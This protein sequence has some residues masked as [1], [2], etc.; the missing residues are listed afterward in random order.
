MLR[1]RVFMTL[2]ELMMSLFW[3]GWNHLI[4]QVGII[5]RSVGT[6]DVDALWVKFRDTVQACLQL[7][8]PLRT[9]KTNVSNPWITREI[10]HLKRKV[11]R[12]KKAKKKRHHSTNIHNQILSVSKE[13]K[14]K[15]REEK[16]NFYNV[17]LSEMVKESPASF[18]RFIKPVTSNSDTFIV[19]KCFYL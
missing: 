14:F 15:M 5:F 1:L 2:Q 16:Y 10:I 6:C 8:V 4:G 3:T 13:L 17:S 9:K 11:K 12:L 7:F 18:W 19:K